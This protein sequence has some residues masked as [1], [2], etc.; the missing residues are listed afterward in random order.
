MTGLY[1]LVSYPKSGSTWLALALGSLRRGGLA[2][3]LGAENA[4][5]PQAAARSMFDRALGIESSSLTPGEDEILRPRLYEVLA[6]QPGQPLMLRVHAAFVRT[7]KGEW[8]FPMELTLGAV[9]IVRDPRDVAVSWA[10]YMDRPIDL[11]IETMGNPA[12]AIGARA[13][14]L[15]PLL[16]Q[17]LLTWSQHVESWLDAGIRLLLVRY[18]DMLANPVSTL[19][20]IAAFLGWPVEE[21]E[22]IAAVESTRFERLRSQEE[23]VGFESGSA[24]SGPFFRRGV[25]GGW[26]ESLTPDQIQRIER[27]HRRVMVRLGYPLTTPDDKYRA[28]I[29]ESF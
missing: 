21:H 28:E 24:R 15:S 12:A 19:S 18:E 26:S 6:R 22:V 2:V 8:L 14:T 16:R 11:A 10:H 25:A 17:R 29:D 3:D 23:K 27:H 20:T 5:F 9:C 4:L 7:S 13:G 1:W